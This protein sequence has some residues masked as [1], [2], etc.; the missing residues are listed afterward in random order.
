[1]SRV[2]LLG[3]TG[4]ALRIARSLRAEHVYS[5]A[6]LGRT[7]VDLAC[8]VRVGGFGGAPGLVRYLADEAIA[9]LVDATHPYA[10]RISANARAASSDARVP[11]WALR[12]P[13][14]EPQA[15]DD[16][17]FVDAWPHVVAALAP[18]RRPLFTLGREPL[19]HLDAIPAH[20]HWTV[21]CL[22]AHPGNERAR[23][24]DARGPFTLDGERALFDAGGYD[25]V[26]S[27]NSGG[28]ATEAK[29]QVARERRLP[30]V[31]LRR[32]ALPAADREFGDVA[33]VIDALRAQPF[34]I[35]R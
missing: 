19:A 34:S 35:V 17:R 8:G 4:D 24:I 1:M 31:M 32:P 12:R 33:G 7:P 2:L 15:D 23:I 6:G 30:V 27:K 25:V 5:L 22:D 14:W 3:G 13:A 29:L 16:W 21:R 26:V 9:L 11:Y 20:Q 10:A 28:A 18:F